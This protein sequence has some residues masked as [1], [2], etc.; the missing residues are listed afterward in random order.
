MFPP[1]YRLALSCASHL[2]RWHRSYRA[3]VRGGADP[4]HQTLR[5]ASWGRG[6]LAPTHGPGRGFAPRGRW[7]APRARRDLARRSG[8]RV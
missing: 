7:A 3:Y 5:A 8:Q 2:R 4:S 1:P 6:P